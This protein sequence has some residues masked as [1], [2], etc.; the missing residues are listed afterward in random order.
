MHIFQLGV[1]AATLISTVVVSGQ[2]SIADSNSVK[3]QSGSVAVQVLPGGPRAIMFRV[4]PEYPRLA[5]AVK[6]I[7]AVQLQALVRADGTVRQVRVVGGHPVLAEAAA[8]AV[9][10][11]RFEPEARETTESVRISFGH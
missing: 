11:W 6:I 8:A 9:M 10:K 7:G 3:S 5:A 1:C 4:T 2:Q